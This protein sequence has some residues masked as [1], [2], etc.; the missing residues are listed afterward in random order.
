MKDLIEFIATSL[1]EHP[2]EVQV[3]SH[4]SG[5]SLF[6]DVTAAPGD[7]GRLIGKRGRTAEAIRAVARVAAVRQGIRVTVDIE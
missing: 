6:V 7:V 5:S 1:V 2:G 4:H 3:D